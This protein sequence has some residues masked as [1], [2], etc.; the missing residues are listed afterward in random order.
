MEWLAADPPRKPFRLSPPFGGIRPFRVIVGRMSARSE[1]DASH[2]SSITDCG[3][4]DWLTASNAQVGWAE[5]R[6]R[7]RP[8]RRQPQDDLVQPMRVLPSPGSRSSLQR[9]SIL[10]L[11]PLRG[12]FGR[13]APRKQHGRGWSERW[14]PACPAAEERRGSANDH[15][16]WNEW[17]R[18]SDRRFG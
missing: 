5:D 1:C 9:L 18:H 17:Q 6:E 16:Q 12:G 14:P 3:K 8:N 2:A 4:L 15:A 7:R 11:T 10:V 13:G